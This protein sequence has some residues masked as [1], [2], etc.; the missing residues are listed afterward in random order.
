MGREKVMETEGIRVATKPEVLELWGKRSGK[1]DDVVGK[2]RK[3]KA[4]ECVIMETGELDKRRFNSIKWGIRST[5]DRLGHKG[6]VK[7]AVKEGK[8]YVW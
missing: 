6:K 1:F 7:F 4:T 8:L 3:L 2:I 5:C